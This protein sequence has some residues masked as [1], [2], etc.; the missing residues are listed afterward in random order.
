MKS[1]QK[2]FTLIELMIVVAIIGILAAVALPAYQDY[3][4]R[5]RVSEGLALAS[6]IKVI[7]GDNAANGTPAANGGFFAGMRNAMLNEVA[8]TANLF[9]G[10]VL[11][12]ATCSD[13]VGDETGTSAGSQNVIS[14]T[15]DVP[16]GQIE[17]RYT[18]RVD[19]DDGAMAA[20]NILVLQPLVN[21]LPIMNGIPPT[22][23]LVWA[24]YAAGKPEIAMAALT[25]MATLLG[26]FA[27]ANCRS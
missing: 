23:S 1:M 27:P 5:G 24:C 21:N 17:I 13:V 16:T 12:P 3:T 15:G 6:P 4:V 22:G 25:T 8:N 7:V 26:K 18:T 9:C 19:S 10:G 11:N 2:G 20:R 14:L